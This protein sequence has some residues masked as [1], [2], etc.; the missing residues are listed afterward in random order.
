[1][2]YD[3]SKVDKKNLQKLHDFCPKILALYMAK[4][5]VNHQDATAS[6]PEHPCG[7]PACAVGNGPS[8]GVPIQD[9]FIRTNGLVDWYGY[10][11]LN[12]IGD[13]SSD[14]WDFAFESDWPDCTKELQARLKLILDENVPDDWEYDS[15][16]AEVK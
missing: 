1:M 13:Y 4:F 3:Y 5:A 7:T 8:A 14:L 10:S 2:L 6:T 11:E 9:T 15:R 16:F 12:F